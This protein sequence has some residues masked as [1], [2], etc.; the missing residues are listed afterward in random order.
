MLTATRSG[1]V[2]ISGGENC[3]SLVYDEA[4]DFWVVGRS[5]GL[6][7]VRLDNSGTPELLGCSH[8]PR[9]GKEPAS[10][11]GTAEAVVS[12]AAKLEQSLRSSIGPITDARAATGTS[13]DPPLDLFYVAG[14]ESRGSRL[15]AS[16]QSLAT[17]LPCSDDG[18]LRLNSPVQVLSYTFN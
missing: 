3:G 18:V 7:V 5:S 13:A 15:L 4:S 2:D 11:V 16:T 1:Q 12:C 10:A 14:T 6:A 17:L 9:P 8:P